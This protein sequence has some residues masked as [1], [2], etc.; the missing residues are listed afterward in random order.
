M[1]STFW[2]LVTFYGPVDA[3]ELSTQT[4]AFGKQASTPT[5]V[6]GVVGLYA[7]SDGRLYSKHGSEA[8]IQLGGGGTLDPDLTDLAGLTA[9]QGDL[10]I[11]GAAADW[12]KLPKGAAGRVL[13]MNA[14]ATLPEWAPAAAGGGSGDVTAAAAFGTILDGKLIH[15]FGV[16]SAESGKCKSL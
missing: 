14:G 7:K 13:T 3:S 11:G 5:I 4:V 15:R 2:D 9:A 1:G 12:V 8:E 10:I 16:L 6:E